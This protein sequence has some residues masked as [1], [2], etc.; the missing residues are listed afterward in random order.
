MT[1]Q[2]GYS[3]GRDKRTRFC[4]AVWKGKQS[5]EKF[6]RATKRNNIMQNHRTLHN[7]DLVGFATQVQIGAASF[8]NKKGKCTYR[9]S[10]TS[11]DKYLKVFYFRSFKPLHSSVHGQITKQNT[12]SFPL[13]LILL[14]SL[15]FAD[16]KC[17]H[18]PT[19]S[20]VG[21]NVSGV[22]H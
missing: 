11:S 18:R 2:F 10:A 1:Q 7:P 19:G 20:A 5:I 16:K 14:L 12:N 8:I 4:S 3:G 17:S 6:E 15:R 9:P 13:L 21:K 22:E